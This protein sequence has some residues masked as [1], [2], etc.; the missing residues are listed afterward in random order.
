M[1]ADPPARVSAEEARE[2]VR[3]AL[4]E[5]GELFDVVLRGQGG[6]EV[7]YYAPSDT[8]PQKP[9]DRDEL[10]FIERGSGVFFVNGERIRFSAGDMLFV[11]AGVEHRF[12][13]FGPSFGAWV[14]FFGERPQP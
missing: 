14:V 12:E 2:R 6:L 8:D 7:E 3:R 11:A 10:Y 1:S 4:S 5:R 13:D 9:H